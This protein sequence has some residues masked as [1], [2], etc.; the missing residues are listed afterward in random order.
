M[1]LSLGTCGGTCL[2]LAGS[3]LGFCICEMEG[4]SLSRINP[5][6]ARG[7]ADMPE[8]LIGRQLLNEL[9][10]LSPD[11]HLTGNLG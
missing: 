4:F 3:S 1:D 7:S 2:F 11:F 5:L 8:G 10:Y 6:G 9:E